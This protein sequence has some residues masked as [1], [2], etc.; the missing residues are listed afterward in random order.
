MESMNDNQDQSAAHDLN[1][2][3]KIDNFSIDWFGSI[4]D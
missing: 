4:N 3:N 1:G 2:R